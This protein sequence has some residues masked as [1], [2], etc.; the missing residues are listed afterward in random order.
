M[1]ATKIDGLIAA[2]ESIATP[3]CLEAARELQDSDTNAES[4][5]LHLRRAGLQ[6]AHAV[7]LA[8]AIRQ[9]ATGPGPQLRSFSAS[10]NRG[11]TDSGAV[12]L[13]EAF[14][15]T[16]SELGLVGCVLG[17]PAGIAILNWVKRAV[18]PGM[19]CVEDNRFSGEVRGQLEDPGLR[20][21][22]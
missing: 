9:L 3:R 10:Y 7:V 15:A 2:L 11:L 6:A 13:A 5:D 18:R 12:A 21:R 1:S 20:R 22:P 17:D 8:D 19:V 16:M 14:P 4:F